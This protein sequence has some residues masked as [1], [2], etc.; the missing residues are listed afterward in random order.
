VKF[1]K[2][3]S[4]FLS[5]ILLTLFASISFGQVS[6]DKNE[7]RIEN[8]T[9]VYTEKQAEKMPIAAGNNLYCAGYIANSS[10]SANV[11]IVG[12]T[13]EK[14]KH[15]FAE[16]DDI[17]LNSG[18]SN[19]VKVGDMFSV[20][21]PRGKVNS[22]WTKKNNLGIWVQEVGAVEVI[23]VSNDVAVARVKSSCDPIMFGDLVAPVV[24]RESPMFSKRAPLDKYAPSSGKASGRIVMS[25]EGR[26][27]LGREMIA[28]VD[29]GREDN[30]SVGDYLTIYRPLGTGNIYTKVPRETGIDNKED[31]YET[32]RY[33][34]GHFSIQASRK[35]GDNAG[36]STVTT[37][38]AKARR[39]AG[40]RR[41][42]GEMIVLNVME[43]TA[44]VMV[45]R[46]ASEIHTGDFVEVQ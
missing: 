20:I 31:G 46:S 37:E 25:R 42:V 34:G 13:E 43:R 21:R 26:E 29:L 28:Y 44:T 22:D 16:G 18:S 40:L 10:V 5:L 33:Q 8:S 39:P 30:V 36:G 7:K 14:D 17:Y 38:G 4:A 1:Q 12:G 6:L 11:E 45:V 24:K 2:T 15:V 23:N 27:M 35:K 32:E 19:G 9:I 3:F 41:V